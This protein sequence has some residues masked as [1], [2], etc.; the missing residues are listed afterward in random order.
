MQKNQNKKENSLV[1]LNTDNP[2]LTQLKSSPL[3]HKP[4]QEPVEAQIIS[5][6]FVEHYTYFT[7]AA[8]KAGNSKIQLLK[9][10]E[11]LCAVLVD[12]PICFSYM[13]WSVGLYVIVNFHM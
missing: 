3:S 6:W 5:N 2:T 4:L 12:V 11:G 8:L 13:I 9:Q 10:P 1:Q 7:P